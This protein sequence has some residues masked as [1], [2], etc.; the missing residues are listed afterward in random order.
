MDGGV[1]LPT[2][3]FYNYAARL[4]NMVHW[5]KLEITVY[6]EL[7]ILPPLSEWALLLLHHPGGMKPEGLNGSGVAIMEVWTRRVHKMLIPGQF[8]VASVLNH[9][10]FQGARQNSDFGEWI[11]GGPSSRVQVN[12]K[13]PNLILPGQYSRP[14]QH[15]AHVQTTVQH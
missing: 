8:I 12:S 2:V 9:P 10:G 4:G 13:T 15:Q 14:I 7:G 3:L 1:A 11:Q 6:W 5:W